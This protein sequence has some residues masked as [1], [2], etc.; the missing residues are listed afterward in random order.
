MAGVLFLILYAG[1]LYTTV[2]NG[3][4]SEFEENIEEEECLV[5]R[6][7]WVLLIILLASLTVLNFAAKGVVISITEIGTIFEIPL[8]YLTLTVA[9]LAT[10]LPEAVVTIQSAKKKQFDIAIGNIIGSNIANSFFIMGVI[11]SISSFT[12]FQSEYLIGVIFL[13]IASVL[14][15]LVLQRKDAKKE[16]GIAFIALYVIYILTTFLR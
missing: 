16:F 4:K 9:A 6:K 8:S 10:S 3:K 15:L 2:R 11:G 1:Y 7:T 5:K 12:F 14:M 13:I